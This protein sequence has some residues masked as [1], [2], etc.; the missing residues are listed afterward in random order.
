MDDAV[1]KAEND[2]AVLSIHY[3]QD[4]ESPRKAF[5]NLGTML[6]WTRNYHS[7]DTNDYSEPRD[8]LQGL[9]EEFYAGDTY[10]LDNWTDKQLMTLIEKHVFILPV[11]KYEHGGIAYSTGSFKGRAHHAEWDSGQVG[12]IF[13]TK[14]A[15]RK[16]WS[17]KRISPGLQEKVLKN[18]KG[19]VAV[20]SAYANGEVYGFTLEK[21]IAICTDGECIGVCTCGSDDVTVELKEIDSCWGFYG[22]DFKTNGVAEHIPEQYLELV[23][24]L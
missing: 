23:G 2:K 19:E 20:Y 8:F 14:E 4:V 15:V 18:L 17:V 12:W 16:E 5:D 7:P 1:Y 24:K 6:T 13:V 10:N 11:Y 3:D 22:S 21:K 9:A